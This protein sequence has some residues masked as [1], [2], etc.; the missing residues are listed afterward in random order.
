LILLLLS[1]QENSL[2][3]GESTETRLKELSKVKKDDSRE[4]DLSQLAIEPTFKG[5]S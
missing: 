5:V 2:K 3:L 4:G 1:S